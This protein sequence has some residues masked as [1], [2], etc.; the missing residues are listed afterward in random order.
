MYK[1][2]GAVDAELA[3]CGA[4]EPLWLWEAEEAV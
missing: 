2:T 3:G 4:V 1:A